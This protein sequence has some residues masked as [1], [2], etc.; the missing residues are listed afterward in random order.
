MTPSQ[1]AQD[2]AWTVR[3]EAE[4]D[5][6][7][8]QRP[9]QRPLED[10]IANGIVLLDK[11]HGPTS[12]Q[13]SVWTKK[14]AG[15]D[16][17]G[18][19]GTLDPHVT[20]VLPVGLDR[21]TRVMGPLSSADKEYVCLMEL[22]TDVPRDEVEAAADDLVGAIEQVP[23]E[24]SAV[25]REQRT[26]TIYDLD[27]LEVDG[28]DVLFRIACEKGFYVR[29]FCEQFGEHLATTGEMVGLR[30]TRVGVFTEDQTVTLQDFADAYA[31]WKAGEETRLDEMVLPIEAGVRHLRKIL[32][33]DSAVAAIAHG[34][35]LGTGGISKLQ[36]GISPGD[37][38]A[39]LTLKGELVATAEA[40][41]DTGTMVEDGGT[42]AVLD[43]VYIGTDVYPREW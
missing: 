8:G 36:E 13:V 29:T 11:P 18:H 25:K 27:V 34:A 14:V 20:G 19:S 40:Q 4:T 2:A 17:A 6:S 42:A 3:E 28:T 26:R 5:W 39:V 23:P 12:N 7:H 10:V 32:V 41:M 33:K 31:F 16:K 9:E 43:R 1:E 21:G 22:G 24:K 35:D 37:Q 15:R 38:V 30:R